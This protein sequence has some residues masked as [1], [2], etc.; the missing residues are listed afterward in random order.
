LQGACAKRVGGFVSTWLGN[1][2]AFLDQL[3]DDRSELTSEA[4]SS[5]AS[6][7]RLG[8]PLEEDSLKMFWRRIHQYPLLTAEREVELARRIE[9]GDRAAHD[10]MVNCNLRLVGSIA[11]KCR[12]YAG[13]AMSLA[14]LIQEGNCGLMKAV[15]KFDYRRGYK[16]S[17]Y[18]SYWIRQSVMR[19]IDEQ[20]RSI[21]LP[22]HVSETVSR[23]D[24][25]YAVLTQQLHRPPTSKELAAHL[26]LTEEKMR[27]LS[28]KG[29]EPMSLDM[30]MGDED[31]SVLMDFLVDQNAPSPVDC[32]SRVALREELLRAFE[33]LSAR[34]VEVLSLRYGFYDSSCGR[35]L[36][37][38][39]AILGLTRERIRQIETGALKRLRRYKPLRETAYGIGGCH[40]RLDGDEPHCA[41][42]HR[43]TW[44]SESS[45]HR[46]S[47]T[48]V[49][50]Q[51]APVKAVVVGAQDSQKREASEQHIAIEASQHL[52]LM[53]HLALKM[54]E[55]PT[56]VVMTNSPRLKPK[57]ASRKS[58]ARR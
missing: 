37:D 58:L 27:E 6:H 42:A 1:K 11:R 16:F 28:G 38:V 33:C 56:G 51:N 4:D 52:T 47:S 48:H 57:T 5:R 50:V 53:N 36:D 31:D 18:A 45:T 49:G 19:A 44:R 25:A 40:T 3:S 14:D 24:R 22:V 26:R 10:E 43:E 12:R 20:A 46:H 55:E 21:R 41:G 35:T 30:A 32:A 23:A 39:G 7:E 29:A 54:Q 15:A 17:T 8:E 34:E 2:R 9:N 13:N